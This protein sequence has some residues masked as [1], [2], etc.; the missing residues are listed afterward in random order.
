VRSQGRHDLGKKNGWALGPPDAGSRSAILPSIIVS[1]Q[2][3]GQDPMADLKALL[4]RLPR[5]THRDDLRAL[6]PRLW[7]PAIA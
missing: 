2:R 6:T 1:G 7:Q 3:H 4:T 5:M